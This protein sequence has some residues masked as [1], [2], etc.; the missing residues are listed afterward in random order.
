[1]HRKGKFNHEHSTSRV[2]SPVFADVLVNVEL[3]SFCHLS[4]ADHFNWTTCRSTISIKN[5]IIFI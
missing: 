1:L 3:H 5:V 4:I 2:F